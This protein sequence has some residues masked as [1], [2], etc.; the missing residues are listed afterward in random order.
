DLRTI[1]RFGIRSMKT[2][3]QLLITMRDIAGIGP[4]IIAKSWPQL[5]EHCRPVVVGDL[6]WLR[7][8]LDMVGSSARVSPINRVDE[9]EP[10]ATVV[11]CL[12]G[13]DQDLSRV[14]IGQVSAAAGR[15]AY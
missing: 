2:Y 14:E 3:P 11:P 5:Q 9:A 7:R 10:T 4:E 13:S 15:A 6:S 12:A 1:F 8:A